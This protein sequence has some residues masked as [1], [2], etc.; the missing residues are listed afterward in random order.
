MKRILTIALALLPLGVLTQTVQPAN[1]QIKIQLGGN[2]NRRP[3]VVRPA[4]RAVIV[5]QR[6][7]VQ[8]RRVWVA[9][10]WENRREN[11]RYRRI[12]V[13]GFYR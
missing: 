6:R 8:Q 11:N 13:P 5:P 7:V 4:P 9:G 2:Q 10:R 12:W 1:A 3:V